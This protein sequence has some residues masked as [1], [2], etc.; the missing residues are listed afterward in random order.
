MVAGLMTLFLAY[1]A[2]FLWVIGYIGDAFFHIAGYFLPQAWSILGVL[3]WAILAVV[4][5][6]WA[7]ARTRK[8]ALFGTR[9]TGCILLL[10]VVLSICNLAFLHPIVRVWEGG[11]L[12]YRAGF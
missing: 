3:C 8:Y 1:N 7:V 10:V 11:E 4:L 6:A 2:Y 12:G 9:K 5:S